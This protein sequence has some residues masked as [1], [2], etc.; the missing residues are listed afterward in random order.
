M[1]RPLY[2]VTETSNM[3]ARLTQDMM[4]DTQGTVAH[5]T[6]SR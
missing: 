4:M 5:T 1:S 2:P 3:Q 6:S